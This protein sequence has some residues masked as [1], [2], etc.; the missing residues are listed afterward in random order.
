M[1]C[2][3]CG[4]E[5]PIYAVVC[6]QCLKFLPKEDLTA[7]KREESAPDPVWKKR[8]RCSRC[9]SVNEIGSAVCAK[10]G[11]PLSDASNPDEEGEL[12]DVPEVETKPVVPETAEPEAAPAEV[13]AK[14]DEAYDFFKK[15]KAIKDAETVKSAPVWEDKVRCRVCWK[16]NPKTATVC[17]Y[18]G[19]ALQPSVVRAKEDEAFETL[20]KK[21]N[22]TITCVNCGKVVPWNTLTCSGCGMHPRKVQLEYDDSEDGIPLGFALVD[23]IQNL[24]ALKKRPSESDSA[25]QEAPAPREQETS[26]PRE[27]VSY[28]SAVKLRCKKCWEFSPPG[29]YRCTHCGAPLTRESKVQAAGRTVCTCG[30]KNL[31]GVTI[32]L[33]CKGIV[34]RN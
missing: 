30:Y 3:N 11:T 34:T 5:N 7:P 9:R 4:H 25:E 13:R 27:T 10:C 26:A 19:S 24:R 29:S 28:T 8:L 20:L 33:M 21:K 1:R 17:G 31:P 6:E 23:Y 18:C 2:T 16:D 22:E 32:C 14:E 12:R 15:Q